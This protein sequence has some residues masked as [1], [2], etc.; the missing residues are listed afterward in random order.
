VG[1]GTGTSPTGKLT[2]SNESRA[3]FYICSPFR[4]CPS[5]PPIIRMLRRFDRS[6]KGQYQKEGD[7]SA[8]PNSSALLTTSAADSY[9]HGRSSSFLARVCGAVNTGLTLPQ[10]TIQLQAP[11]SRELLA[12]RLSPEPTRVIPEPPRGWR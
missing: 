11:K 6:N 1:R 5:L 9:S 3:C 4:Y 8:T 10:S 2:R 12:D 7:Y